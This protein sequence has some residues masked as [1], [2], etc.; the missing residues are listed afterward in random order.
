MDLHH[1]H[2]QSSCSVI[3]RLLNLEQKK[4]ISQE[5]LYNNENVIAIRMVSQKEW[6]CSK[7]G[8]AIRMV[9]LQET[10]FATRLVS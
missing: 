7:Y 2:I 3:E 4:L 9:S 10:D 5:E 8:F 6:F 1:E